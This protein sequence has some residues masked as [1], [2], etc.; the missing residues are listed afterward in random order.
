M[1][2]DANCS[3][4]HKVSDR[5]NLIRQDPAGLPIRQRA[6]VK[7]ERSHGLGIA[8]GNAPKSILTHGK[9][10]GVFVEKGHVD[11]IVGFA[12]EHT[13][14]IAHPIDKREANR[15]VTTLLTGHI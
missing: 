10:H 12:L 2:Q 6:L 5:E 8:D 1:H 3:C 4:A 11:A 14:A 9:Q 15:W 13:D 7:L